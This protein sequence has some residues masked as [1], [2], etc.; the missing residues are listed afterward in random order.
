MPKI[1]YKDVSFQRSS[2]ET[3][4]VA[5]AIVD[6]YEDQGY[7]LTL[8]QLYYQLVARGY[9]ENNERSYKRI[10]NLINDAR[11]AGMIDWCSITDRTRNMR[12]NSHWDTPQQILLS[13]IRQYAIDTR[14]NQPNYY[15]CN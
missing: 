13:A 1:A 5:V 14:E 10:G 11:L 15:S 9:I 8:R 12:S 2:L 3:I 4:G 6:E 7:D